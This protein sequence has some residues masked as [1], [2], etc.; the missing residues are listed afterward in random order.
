MLNRLMVAAGV[1]VLPT[2]V[3]A[4]DWKGLTADWAALT[5]WTSNPV[6]QF[7]TIRVSIDPADMT[8][9]G[10]TFMPVIDSSHNTTYGMARIRN[11]AVI[12]QTGGFHKWANGSGDGT[13]SAWLLG[14]AGK[15]T[16]LNISG[17]TH[18]V[19]GRFNIGYNNLT[20]NAAGNAAVNISGTGTLT[21]LPYSWGNAYDLNINT[22]SLMTISD[23][24]RLV[25]QL[26]L[27]TK[28]DTLISAGRIVAGAEQTLSTDFDFD[29]NLYI[30]SAVPE[31][32]SLALIALGGLALVR[33]RRA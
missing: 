4:Q 3:F 7:Q 11:G 20:P 6:N 12:T 19:D 9:N 27:Q 23:S 1:L 22:N 29:N 21:V 26:P 17:G 18:E 16:T 25:V 32:A 24:G 30:V 28:V 14:A 5:N 15:T 8:A 2:V 10:G 13:A 33:R 31:P